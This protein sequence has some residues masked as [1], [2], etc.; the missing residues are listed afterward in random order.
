MTPRSD[1]ELVR[2]VR[3]GSLEAYGELVQRY[4]SA[5]FNTCYRVLGRRLEAEDLAQETFIRGYRRLETFD[6][7]RPFGPWI[8][9]IAVNLCLNHLRRPGLQDAPLDQIQERWL[10]SS[11]GDPVAILVR[12]EEAERVWQAIQELPPHYR[13]VIELRHFQDLSYA[14]IGEVL[15]IPLNHVRTHLHRAR[16][17]LAQ[18]LRDDG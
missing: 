6:A 16:K 9:R 3:D 14:E 15:G 11:R 8:R 17:A 5:V 18:R 10:R 12:A 13:A 7:G 2:C 1:A 4:Q